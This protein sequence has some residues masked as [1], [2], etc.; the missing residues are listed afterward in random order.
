M[1]GISN[2]NNCHACGEPAPVINITGNLSSVTSDCRPWSKQAEIAVCRSCG[3]SQKRITPEWVKEVENIYG[4]YTMYSQGG[5]AEQASFESESG[6][7]QARSEKIIEALAS[8]S[9]LPNQGKMLDV[10]CGNGHMI[11]SF[12]NKFPD[13]K[14]AG[15]E[16]DDRHAKI[17]RE[18][19]NVTDFFTSFPDDH[20]KSFDLISMVHVLEH[21]VD[22]ANYLRKLIGLLRD[23][24]LLL[25]EVPNLRRNPYDI[26]IFDH[27]SHFTASSLRTVLAEAGFEISWISEDIV[28]KELTALCHVGAFEA[29]SV[30]LND[31]NVAQDSMIWLQTFKQQFATIEPETHFGIFGTSIGA[32]WVASELGQTPDFFLDEDINRI[33]NRHLDKPIF[34]PNETPQGSIIIIPLTTE[35]AAAV[36]VRISR[37]DLRLISPPDSLSS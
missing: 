35:S 18:I 15:Q 3:L 24:G 31:L 22:P 26:A 4:S 17:V 34:A 33:G 28:S 30:I 2:T 11:R 13:W 7:T 10:G 37:P 32:S 12:Q 21:I 25:I 20:V 23:G 27:C 8:L 9:L 19:P 36:S 1:T 29:D 16:W 14:L 5:G 6:V